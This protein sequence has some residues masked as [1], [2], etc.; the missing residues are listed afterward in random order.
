MVYLHGFMYDSL[1]I[2]SSRSPT[3]QADWLRLQPAAD[4]FS[5]PYRQLAETFRSL[6]LDDER[7]YILIAENREAGRFVIAQDRKSFK[8]SPDIVKIAKLH[9]DYWWYRRF[10]EL[11][12]FGYQPSHALF[13]SIAVILVGIAVFKI[14]YDAGLI[15]PNSEEA[16]GTR[17]GWKGQL[18]D[19]YPKFNTLIYSI[20][21]FVPLVKL[22]IDEHWM[23]NANRGA[24]LA[25]LGKFWILT[26]GGLLRGY[27]WLHNSAGWVLT[28]LSVGALTGLIK[29]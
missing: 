25:S 26:V 4:F 24:M 2:R 3:V 20:E 1:H 13:L 16:F 12:G 23:I 27:L 21:T 9:Y 5:Q 18:K 28:T 22:G 29:S 14:G 15:I 6:G 7:R 10:G 19:T 17:D 11:I 8:E